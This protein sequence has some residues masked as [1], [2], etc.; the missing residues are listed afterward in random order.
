VTTKAGA[1]RTIEAIF[2]KDLD[3]R[4]DFA[5]PYKSLGRVHRARMRYAAN[6]CGAGVASIKIINVDDV[7]ADLGLINM[8]RGEA[9]EIEGGAR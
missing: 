2:P 5:R 9:M 8:T 6:I 1:R 7:E 4:F 3:P